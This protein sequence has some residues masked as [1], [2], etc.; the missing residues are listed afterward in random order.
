MVGRLKPRSVQSGSSSALGLGQRLAEYC[1]QASAGPLVLRL[2]ALD[3]LG[4][5]PDLPCVDVQLHTCAA[6]HL[7]NRRLTRMP[8]P[9]QFRGP[10]VYRVLTRA[11]NCWGLPT[12]GS[13]TSTPT[14]SNAEEPCDEESKMFRQQNGTED[15]NSRPFALLRVTIE[16]P[17]YPPGLSHLRI[18]PN[19]PKE[20][21]GSAS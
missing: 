9:M 8:W 17:C 20:G 5:G 11:A 15:R 6:A 4:D 3:A 19:P 1:R 18:S 12:A 21:V 10:A 2:M 14:L 7:H 13:S 16:R